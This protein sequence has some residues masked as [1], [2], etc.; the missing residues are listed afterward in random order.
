MDKIVKFIDCAIETYT[1]NLR[2]HY[3]V[4]TQKRLFKNKLIHIN[5]TPEEIRAAFSPQRFGGICMINLCAGGETLLSDDVIPF[6]RILLEL[7][8]YVMIVTNATITPRVE[9]ITRLPDYLKKHL[10]LKCSFQ[11]HEMKRLGWV[12]RFCDNVNDLRRS[13][14]SITVEVMPTDEMIPDIDE[15]K[16]VCMKEF[17]AFCHITV[18]RNIKSHGLDLLSKISFDEYNKAWSQFNSGL[19][20]FKMSLYHKK[21]KEYCHAGDWT[22]RIEAESGIV[23]QCYC[24]RVIGN[25]YNL[26]KPLAYRSIGRRCSL[27]FCFNGHAF[28]AFGAIPELDTPTFASLR[29]RVTVT[30]EHWLSSDVETIMKQKIGENIGYKSGTKERNYILDDIVYMRD[31]ILQ[32]ARVNVYKLMAKVNKNSKH[33]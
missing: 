8:H 18:G 16:K 22:L 5:R 33:R 6:A 3:C 28:L 31:N 27:P 24:G 19:F 30:G 14:C 20:S 13:G 15:L 32:F 10:F 4:V 12:Q 2:C 7:G 26:D 25:I 17:G 11:Y 29:D 21:R 1:C 9:E 23:R